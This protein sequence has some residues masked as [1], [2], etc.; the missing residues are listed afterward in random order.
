M[1]AGK[2]ELGITIQL[3]NLPHTN[4]LMKKAFLTLC[5]LVSASFAMA[6]TIENNEEP[7]VQKIEEAVKPN[8]SCSVTTVTGDQNKGY[9]KTITITVS[10]TCTDA[11]ACDQ[12][13]SML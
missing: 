2:A 4:N 9:G 11:E 8:G 3:T 10:C 12:L 1:G 7:T 5:F 13:I 6:N